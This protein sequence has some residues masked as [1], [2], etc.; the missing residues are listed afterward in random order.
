VSIL[1]D[2]CTEEVAAFVEEAREPELL[3]PTCKLETTDC[4]DDTSEAVDL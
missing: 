3:N 1:G 4:V 2:S